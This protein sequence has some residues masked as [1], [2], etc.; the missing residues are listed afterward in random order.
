MDTKTKVQHANMAARGS[1]GDTGVL[2]REFAEPTAPVGLPSYAVADLPSASE[3]ANHAVYC[4][5]G[6]AG[7][8]ILAFSNGT[9]WLRSD[10]GAAV[11]VV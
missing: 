4:S 9:N 2:L 1:Y 7:S 6:A 8:P 3:Y 5:D 10:T 11:A